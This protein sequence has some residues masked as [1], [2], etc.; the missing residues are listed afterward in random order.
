MSR[1]TAA[2]R[3]RE[4][5]SN[6][7]RCTASPGVAIVSEL[8]DDDWDDQ[9]EGRDDENARLRDELSEMEGWY[10]LLQAEHATVEGRLGQSARR[11]TELQA[12]ANRLALENHELQTILSRTPADPLVDPGAAE[13]QRPRHGQVMLKEKGEYTAMRRIFELIRSVRQHKWA[14]AAFVTLAALLA[15][16][17]AV[18][19][20][21]GSGWDRVKQAVGARSREGGSQ[22]DSGFLR[23]A[24]MVHSREQLDRERREYNEREAQLKGDALLEAQDRLRSARNRDRQAR[25]AFLPELAR[26]CEEARIPLPREAAEALASLKTEVAE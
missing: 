20:A 12:E 17:P 11:L 22:A 25:L 7:A 1:G 23:Y 19:S 5:R 10:R 18:Q 3:R 26:Q 4:H 21:V 9:D 13:G 14:T 8:Y 24:A 16:D 2:R 6:E 15:R